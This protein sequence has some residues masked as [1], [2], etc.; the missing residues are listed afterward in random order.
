MINRY[1]HEQLY[2]PVC[3][4]ALPKDTPDVME[5]TSKIWEGDD[6]VPYVW[7]EWLTDY[8]GLLAVCEYGGRVVALGKLTLLSAGQWWLEGLRVH[9]EYEGRG[10]A[11]HVND[12]IMNYWIKNGDGKVRL[13]TV[14]NREKVI[15]LSEK[16]GFQIIGKV[17]NYSVTTL[18]GD[19]DRFRKLTTGDY[20]HVIELL[21]QYS[22]PALNNG[23]VDLGWQWAVPVEPLL[24]RVI[25]REGAWS[26]IH[27]VYGQGMLLGREDFE[28]E[29][30]LYIGF[31]HCPFEAVSSCLR[32]IR[33]LAQAEG[34]KKV[35]WFAPLGL[36]LNV[37]L[38]SAGFERE[39]D[40][41]LLIYEKE[42]PSSPNAG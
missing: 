36:D 13:A 26:W 40:K 4:P 12:Y 20:P 25:E 37:M 35:A 10:I 6:Y 24:R 38:E 9:P 33:S 3:R 23:L 11:S 28:D 32:D 19:T 5:L 18:V 1:H 42:H 2:R 29:G 15:H 39:W 14:S 17:T 31:L 27:P 21:N 30:A 34:Y 16:R 41:Y 7:D 8:E 22:V